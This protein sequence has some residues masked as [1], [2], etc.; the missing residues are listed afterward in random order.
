[1]CSLSVWRHHKSFCEP[2][3]KNDQKSIRHYSEQICLRNITAL[4]GLIWTNQRNEV[5]PRSH[6]LI[7]FSQGKF[8]TCQFCSIIFSY[9]SFLS[10]HGRWHQKFCTSCFTYVLIEVWVERLEQMY[11][12]STVTELTAGSFIKTWGGSGLRNIQGFGI[13]Y[14][15]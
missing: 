7:L 6:G 3:H 5:F 12:V 15:L 11:E 14:L 8:F 13:S 4:N 9:L 10:T 1:M 2:V